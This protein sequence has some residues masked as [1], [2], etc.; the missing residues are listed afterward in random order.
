MRVELSHG[1]AASWLPK[2]HHVSS[3]GAKPL[4]LTTTAVPPRTLPARGDPSSTSAAS[5]YLNVTRSSGEV[6]AVER[7]LERA[8][9]RRELAH[10]QAGRRAHRHGVV[11]LEQGQVAHVLGSPSDVNVTSQL[12]PCA[13]GTFVIA[14]SPIVGSASSAASSAAADASCAIVA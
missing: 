1:R 8:A 9:A 13:S 12:E 10:A 6:D 4:P 11:R 3:A 7:E 5:S 2:R 14:T